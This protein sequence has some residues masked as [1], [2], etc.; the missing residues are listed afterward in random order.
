MRVLVVEDDRRMA[1]LLRRGLVGE[2]WAVDV[3]HDGPSG[4]ERAGEN[5][6]DAIVLDVML[7]GLNGY[8][9][10]G[11]L[12]EAGIW[13]PVLMLT[14]MDGEYDE[15]EG[16]D[17]GADDYVT[18]PFSFVTLL[19]RLRALM[20]RGQP[21][22]PA[23]LRIGDLEVDPAARQCR[24]GTVPVALTAREFSV[25][26][27]LMRRADQ[28]NPKFDI[29]NGVWEYD[30][31]GDPNIV[32]VYVRRLRRKVDEPFNRH[33]LETVRGAGYRLASSGR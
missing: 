13:A 19:A 11:R 31:G 4:L 27:Y 32:E 25:L 3:V 21:Q 16:L 15:A 5:P 33:N 9:V 14:A 12:R 2:G 26:E 1:E 8:A 30:F 20:R 22:R 29:L 18:K 17:V 28:V 10:C 7:P 24:R 6:Y 23:V